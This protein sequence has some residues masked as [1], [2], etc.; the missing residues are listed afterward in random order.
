VCDPDP[1]WEVVVRLRA[2]TDGVTE[3]CRP[4]TTLEEAA[5]TM[6]AGNIGSLGVVENGKLI[7]IVTERDVLRATAVGTDAATEPVERWMTAA[8]DVFSPEV[9]VAEAARWLLETGYRHLPVVEGD[10]LLGIVSIRAVLN[11]ATADRG[12]SAE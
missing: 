6:I 1:S 10:E 3:T 9:E 4:E 5:R 8:P 7:G 11:A 2:L 12:L